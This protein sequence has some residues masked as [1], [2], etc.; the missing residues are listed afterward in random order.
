MNNEIEKSI[1]SYEK[2]L[3]YVKNGI[4]SGSI[5][6]GDKLPTERYLADMLN[7]GR[8]SVREG[9]RVLESLG[10]AECIQG[11]GNYI[12]DHFEE[13]LARVVTMIVLLKKINCTEI[14]DFRRGLEKQAMLLCI[15]SENIDCGILM[16]FAESMRTDN[17]EECTEFDSQ[18]HRYI[19][20]SADNTLIT[21]V[22]EALS[23]ITS[24]LIGNVWKITDNEE[25][26]R[27]VNCHIKI[28]ECL[29]KRD[30]TKVEDVVNKH[31]D[32][33]DEI[34]GKEGYRK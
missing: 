7:I 34:I 26:F 5:K 24:S 27:L 23:E 32:L 4:V 12:S 33:V 21:T 20:D 10:I 30:K 29:I 13:G 2:V 9:I 1:K 3:E 22:L 28:A 19:Y 11:G 31:Y 16:K 18:F 15:D 25:K 14:D 17:V 8:Y 6:Q